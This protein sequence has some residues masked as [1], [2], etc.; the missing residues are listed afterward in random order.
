MA[1]IKILGTIFLGVCAIILCGGLV[2]GA[3]GVGGMAVGIAC[4][5]VLA[6]VIDRLA[7]RKGEEGASAE[8]VQRL[9]ER[10]A[11]LE[12]RLTDIQEV[13]ISLSEKTEQWETSAKPGEVRVW[14]S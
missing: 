7:K 5:A 9:E 4:L 13:Q 1:P 14:K 11:E 3:V 12:R 8:Q 10:L 6:K 2:A